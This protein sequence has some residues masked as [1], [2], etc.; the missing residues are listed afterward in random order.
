MFSLKH[1]WWRT[2]HCISYYK[3][4]RNLICLPLLFSFEL[5]S[6]LLKLWTFAKIQYASELYKRFLMKTCFIDLYCP[7]FDIT[8]NSGCTCFLLFFLF[9]DPVEICLCDLVFFLFSFLVPFSL[10]LNSLRLFLFLKLLAECHFVF[11]VFLHLFRFKDFL[12]FCLLR[13]LTDASL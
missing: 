8:F 9:I 10:L 5:F 7:L 6:C 1:P 3:L 12:H 4:T 11:C 2:Q 13:F